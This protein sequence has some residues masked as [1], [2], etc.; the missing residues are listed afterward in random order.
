MATADVDMTVDD[1]PQVSLLR[2]VVQHIVLPPQL[3]QTLHSPQDD[4]DISAHICILLSDAAS[5][6]ATEFPYGHGRDF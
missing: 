1:D 4:N 6:Y 3:P 5:Q 2:S